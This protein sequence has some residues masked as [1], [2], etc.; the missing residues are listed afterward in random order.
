M[1]N[2]PI[3]RVVFRLVAGAIALG[4][5]GC[6]TSPGAPSPARDIPATSWAEVTYGAATTSLAQCLAGS[7]AAA[8]FSGARVHPLSGAAAPITSAPVFNNNQPV[9]NSGPSVTLSWSAPSDGVALSYVVEASSTPGGPANL[10]NFNTGN[11]Q[12]TLVVPSVPAGTYYVRIR[13]LDAGGAS[14]PSNEVAVIVVDAAGGSCPSAPR[15][16]TLASL[17]GGTVTL[18]WQPPAAGAP[19]S[20]VIQ[21]GSAPNGANLANFDTNST[22]LTL[23]AS[24]V[25]AGAYFVRVYAKNSSCAPPTFLG[26]SSNEILL[27]VGATAAPGWSGQIVCRKVI[28]GPSSYHHDETQAWIIAGPGQTSGPRTIYPVQWSAQGSGGGI[29]KSWTMNTAAVT[30]LS[31]TTV[32]STGIPIFDRTTTGLII[33]GGYVG[34]P[35]SFDLPEI[36][37]PTIVAPSATATSVVGTYSRPTVGGDSPQQPGGSTGTL[38]CNWSLAFR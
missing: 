4:S 31:V 9:L 12:T 36:D 26:P 5:I 28:T 20:Y 10:A 6:A 33:R 38:T 24:N 11:A 17:S 23:V 13:A 8:C 18:A 22:A 27:T 3:V 2:R 30:D 29:G 1:S 16:L 21:A 19:S 14:A 37:F 15:A 7:G 25:P 35:T 34:T 32:A